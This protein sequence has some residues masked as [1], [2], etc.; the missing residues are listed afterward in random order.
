M[1]RESPFCLQLTHVRPGHKNVV[2]NLLKSESSSRKSAIVSVCLA[3]CLI[4]H[5]GRAFS[6]EHR[7]KKVNLA[8]A[9]KVRPLKRFTLAFNRRVQIAENGTARKN[10]ENEGRIKT[11]WGLCRRR[12]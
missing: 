10:E 1:L 11:E 4:N 12:S 3:H 9:D 8:L 6:S 2:K 5:R 7:E